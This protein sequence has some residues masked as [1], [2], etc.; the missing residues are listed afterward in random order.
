MIISINCLGIEGYL[1][2]SPENTEVIQT[3]EDANW[4]VEN[5][6]WCIISKSTVCEFEKL[7]YPCCSPENTE[8]SFYLIL[9]YL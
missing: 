5:E 6:N 1:C 8:V 3:D 2:C 7:G 9:L 4:C